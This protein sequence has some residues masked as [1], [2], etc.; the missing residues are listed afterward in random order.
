[1]T[2]RSFDHPQGAVSAPAVA[3]GVPLHVAAAL[4]TRRGWASMVVVDHGSACGVLTEHDLLRA[5]VERD[6]RGALS[7]G[8][9]CCR[10]LDE[11]MVA[12][13]L[14]ISTRA[15][16]ADAARAMLAAGVGSAVVADDEAVHGV[17]TAADIT[18]APAW[19]RGDE[20]TRAGDACVDVAA[21]SVGDDLARAIS[22]A[23]SA[24]GRPLPVLDDGRAVGLLQIPAAPV[25]AR[26]TE[27]DL[28]GPAPGGTVARRLRHGARSDRPGTRLRRG[29]R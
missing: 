27:A 25:A 24:G 20:Q 8:D 23:G 11:V 21:L 26:P 28:G 16:V 19:T 5:A 1:M 10:D 14:V 18:A 12:D 17:L 9:V 2:V 13:P 3:V 22:L 15:T 4:M 6:E 7:V 29:T